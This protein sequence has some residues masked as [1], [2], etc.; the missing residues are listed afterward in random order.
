M[1]YCGILNQSVA[2][3]KIII[4]SSAVRDEG[5]SYHYISRS[6]EISAEPS[7][8][9]M[10]T[11]SLERNNIPYVIGKV[12]TTD[13]IYRETPEVIEE[14]RQQGCIAVEMECSASLSVA[15]FRNVPIIQFL[16]GADNLDSDKWEQRDLT[17]Y[18]LKCSSKYLA[19][20]LE[21]GAAICNLQ[22]RQVKNGS[23]SMLD[24][25]EQ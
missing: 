25:C 5:T 3:N 4:P 11:E 1:Y 12:W 16:F 13:A 15:K 10:I 20:A 18:G 21:C 14:R 6:E 17:D 24:S 2:E 9:K 23:R 8:I 7:S 19:I 22:E